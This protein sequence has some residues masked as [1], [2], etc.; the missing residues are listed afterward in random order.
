[1]LIDNLLVVI[2]AVINSNP[3][4][5]LQSACKLLGIIVSFQCRIQY[6]LNEQVHVMNAHIQS[7]LER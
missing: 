7:L 2:D 1:M 5:K 4:Q 6:E 3:M